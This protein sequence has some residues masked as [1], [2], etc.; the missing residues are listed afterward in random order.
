MEAVKKGLGLLTKALEVLMVVILAVMVVVMFLQVFLRYVLST[1]WPWT[2]ELTRFAM[3]YMIF[4]GAAILTSFDGHISVTI[5]DGFL[6]GNAHKVL[7]LVQYAITLVY[8]FIMAR[9][10]F[11]AL[12]IVSLQKSPNMQITMN[13]IYIVMPVGM[14]LMMV[15]ILA[16]CVMLFTDTPK[17]AEIETE[18]SESI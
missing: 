17:Q 6:K 2:E 16:K 13:L 5:L 1:G 4:I 8:C 10:G 3:V 11:N 14:I 7:K 9:A 12:S 18:G 15:Y